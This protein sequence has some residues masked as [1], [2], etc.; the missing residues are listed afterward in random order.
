MQIWL[1]TSG[2]SF[3]P[4]WRVFS[5]FAHT[6]HV[7]LD[8]AYRPRWDKLPELRA[9]R[10]L[11][12]A[13]LL[14]KQG[15]TH[16]VLPPLLELQRIA[17]LP[18]WF[19]AWV[20]IL[21]LF[22]TYLLEEVLPFSL[23]G[24]LGMLTQ[25]VDQ[26]DIKKT[27]HTRIATYQ[28]T[29]AQHQTKSFNPKFPLRCKEVRLRQYLATTLGA[30]D[31]M[32]RKAIKHDVRYFLDAHVDTLIP[33]SRSMLAFEHLLK[34]KAWV[35]GFK[36]HGSDA[37]VRTIEKIAP[38]ERSYPPYLRITATS[39]PHFHANSHTTDALLSCAGN[40]PVE[41]LYMG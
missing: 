2:A 26:E 38:Q 22:Q 31:P 35:S 30:R 9:E 40:V 37:L 20:T 16:I 36:F 15:V 33:S 11:L 8:R 41:W 4:L 34:R 1:L 14:A 5:R 3:F 21:P 6:Y 12:G 10:C 28:S 24:K 25:R 7:F 17:Q 39:Q 32:V 27:I 13:Q 18:E 19:P 23:V 29:P